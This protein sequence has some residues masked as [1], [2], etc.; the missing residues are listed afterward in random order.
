MAAVLTTG[1]REEIQIVVVA[2]EIG[3]MGAIQVKGEGEIG[4]SEK[5]TEIKEA[6]ETGTMVNTKVLAAGAKVGIQI[7]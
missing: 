2:L 6:V 4:I 7:K 3:T 1:I 5:E